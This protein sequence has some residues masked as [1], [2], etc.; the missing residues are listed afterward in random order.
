[1]LARAIGEGANELET[2]HI[3]SVAFFMLI[4]IV[5]FENSLLLVL[6][7]DGHCIAVQ[8][9]LIEDKSKQQ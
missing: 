5:A 8:K 9:F 7:V 6:T 2:S 3:L 1:M 4:I